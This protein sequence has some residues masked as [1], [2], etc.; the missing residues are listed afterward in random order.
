M[1]Q[2]RRF[3]HAHIMLFYKAVVYL[4]VIL[5]TR[6]VYKADSRRGAIYDESE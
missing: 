3:L 6:D 5:R 4:T 2:P 1:L